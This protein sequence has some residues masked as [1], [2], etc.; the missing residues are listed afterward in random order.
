VTPQ[1]LLPAPTHAAVTLVGRVR[2]R[3][4]C[5]SP[6]GGHTCAAFR[7]VGR[8]DRYDIDD[9][10][11]HD[12]DL[13]MPNGHTLLVRVAHAALA[14][15]TE[16]WPAAGTVT[17]ELV[18]FLGARGLPAP[19]EVDLGE[20]VLSDGDEVSVTGTV[21]QVAVPSGL[22]GTDYRAEMVGEPKAPV[23]IARA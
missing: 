6:V 3:A 21:V 5:T 1:Q 7:L 2:L 20:S 9:A 10:G 18:R 23:V 12:F 17:P 15:S 8:I 19:R 11:G 13:V 4:P 22:R 14:I 16:S